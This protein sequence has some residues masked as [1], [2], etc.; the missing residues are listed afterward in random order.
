MKSGWMWIPKSDP[1][2]NEFALFCRKLDVLQ[3]P[4]SL[5]IKISADSRYKFYVNDTLVEFGPSKGNQEQWYYDE[6]DLAPHLHIG[7]NVLVVQVLHYSI[8]HWR[9]NNS[10]IRTNTPGF[11]F[12][13]GKTCDGL[14]WSDWKCKKMQG[15]QLYQENPYFAPLW[16]YEKVDR[17]LPEEGWQEPY[18]Y[19]ETEVAHVLR[20]SRLQKREIPFMQRIPRAFEQMEHVSIAAH[21]IYSITL[22]AGELMTAFLHLDCIGGKNAEITI[23]QAESYAGDIVV[24]EGD[25]YGSLPRKGDR[26]DQK[27]QLHG[28]SDYYKVKGNG[29]A[30]T[31]ERY[32]PFWM[33]TFRFIRLTIKTADAPLEVKRFHYDETGYPLK[34]RS[35][36]ETSD[37]RMAEV[38]NICERSLR[39]CMHETYMDCP[40]Y[41]QL[42]YAMDTRSQILY[43]YATAADP[44]LAIKC[45]DD[46]SNAARADGMIAC[47][48]PNYETSVIPGFGIYYVGMVYD[49]MMYFG[50]RKR[51]DTYLP[52][53]R[54]I[55]NF[56]KHHRLAN[57]LVDKV[58]DLNRPGNDWS[59]IDWTPE[60]D[61]SN[62]V[63][64]A[65]LQGP[66]TMESL[67]YLLGLQYA[68]KIV[69]YMGHAEEAA[70]YDRQSQ[71]LKKAIRS[72]CMG[73][74]GMLQD[75]PG[76]EMYSQHC[77]VFGVLTEILSVSEG[78]QALRKTL[79]KKEDYAQCSIAMMYYLFRALE[80]CKAYELTSDLWLVWKK[81]LDEHLTT[82]AEDQLGQRSD[83]H[84]W[85]A[86]AL[87]ELPAVVLGV[88]PAKPA[89]EAIEVSPVMESF[90]WAR[91][92][93]ITPKGVVAV[94]WEKRENGTTDLQVDGPEGVEIYIR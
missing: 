87:Y 83:C 61:A 42:Q 20:F 3:L 9:G 26:I 32:E 17:T 46:F 37:P 12:A 18:E 86:L 25:P 15:I 11:F 29:S 89:Y 57:G 82:C 1:R 64:S 76:V 38:W 73:Y 24:K 62:G 54:G 45:M 63:P 31:P 66:I 40:F 52:T 93:V 68:Q 65:T 10:C 7:S 58:G 80:M 88:H 60:W 81:M 27:L 39:R 84:A 41:E 43:T 91:G 23:L 94:S 49:Y 55:L 70:E 13:D 51:I 34:I 90:D 28:Y 47:S 16:I 21:Q 33:R 6:I 67:L 71:E 92:E 50:D 30:L 53:V 5:E 77:Q 35:H 79:E 85:G 75:G 48:F 74:H 69:L 44:R 4:K 22:D 19:D 72:Q 14:T 2:A 78:K 8:D 56:F 36:A 59:F